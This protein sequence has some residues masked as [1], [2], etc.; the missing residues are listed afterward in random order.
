MKG[1]GKK[2]HL[3]VEPSPQWFTQLLPLPVPSK[4]LAV[5]S[6]AKVTALLARASSLHDAELKTYNSSENK[7]GIASSSADATF[8]QKVLQAGTL[9]DKLSAL[10]LLVQSSPLHNTKAL[11]SLKGMAERG[12]GKGGREESLKALRCI[13]DW[14]VGGGGPSRKLKYFRDQPLLHPDVSE[15]HLLIWYFEDWL[16]KYFFSVIQIMETLSL[17]PLP[18]VRT[19]ALSQI[20]AL[21]RSQPEQEQNLLRL[22]VNKL[23]DS[24]RT[25]CSRASHHVLQLLQAHPSM[26]LVVVREAVSRMFHTALSSSASA[27]SKSTHIRFGDAGPKGHTKDTPKRG[28]RNMHARYYTTITFNQIVLTPKERDVAVQLINVYFDLFKDLLGEGGEADDAQSV[29]EKGEKDGGKDKGGKF[30]KEKGKDRKGKGREVNADGMFT[31]IEDSNSRLISAL[32]TGINRA[33]PFAKISEGDLGFN[34]HID[35]L[36]LITHKSTF[37]ISLQALVL[38]HQIC[39]SLRRPSPPS[40]SSKPSASSSGAQ[41]QDRYYRTLYASLHDPRL[42]TSNKQ[43]MYL[44]LLFKSLKSDPNAARVKA[45]I[46]RFV[47]VIASGAFGGCGTEFIAGG[48]FL[49]GELF[50]TIPGLRAML[51]TPPS[52]SENAEAYDPKKRDPQY[53]HAGSSPL[54]ELTPLLHHFHPSVALHARQLLASQPVTA[55]PDLALN[56]LSHFLDRFVYKNPK[57]PKLKGDSAMQPAVAATLGGGATGV[58]LR[59]G[60]VTD[61]L[62]LMNEEQLLKRR[63]EDVPEDQL[64]FH[65][66]FSAKKRKEAARS[67]AAKRKERGE[68]EEDEEDDEGVSSDDDE[69]NDEDKGQS[70]ERGSESE[71]G[72]DEEEAEIWKAMKATMPREE[73]DDDLLMDDEDEDDLPSDL[74][75]AVA[76]DL[77]AD[78]DAEAGPDVADDDQEEDEDAESAQDDD[79][80]DDGLS[81]AEASDAEDLVDLDEEVPEGLIPYDGSDAGTDE[82]EGDAE[83]WGGIGGGTKKRK[84]ASEVRRGRK[85]LKSLPTFATYED[86]AAMIEN[87]AED[88]I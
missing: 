35:T 9:S 57:K 60:E 75:D 6:P 72:S 63:P 10:T 69:H 56:T 51:T 54:W 82:D 86:Y 40:S 1:T 22:L 8:L 81:L 62:G 37:N 84:R 17:D 79:D 26:K 39:V 3:L 87:S 5:A 2:P 61:G 48:L 11:E 85:K 13:V 18:Y 44:N 28:Q 42:A 67:K 29:S 49:L 66:Y 32:L 38:I 74:D 88:N 4:P 45:V 76:D 7:A 46:R 55:Q 58:H 30:Q 34:R 25:I 77:S 68:D 41:V 73:G 65:K 52:K 80:D 33:L 24:D 14:W 50:S 23:G 16:K 20:A 71:D 47:Q 21:L 31:E 12:K 19:Q 15:R 70:A 78:S 43:A 36:F 27:T 83:E 53:A 64:F 59:R